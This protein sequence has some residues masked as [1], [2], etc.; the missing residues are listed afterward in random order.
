LAVFAAALALPPALFDFADF[1]GFALLAVLGAAFFAFTALPAFRPFAAA[2]GLRRF[3]GMTAFFARLTT[4]FAVAAADCAAADAADAACCAVSVTTAAALPMVPP[5]ASAVRVSAPCSVLPPAC[6]SDIAA[7]FAPILPHECC[8]A[9]RE[10]VQRLHRTV[11]RPCTSA[12]HAE[13]VSHTNRD[14]TEKRNELA[15]IAGRRKETDRIAR[16]TYHYFDRI[17]AELARHGLVPTPHTA[18]GQLR[19]AVRELYKY[20]IRRLRDEHVAG[21]IPKRDYAGCV[22]QLRERYPLLSV[23]IELWTDAIED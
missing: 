7:P 14:A 3:A 5:T 15:P 19:D 6:S 22:I 9:F 23:P 8:E 12:Q 11:H 10:N 17:L 2:A 16:V 4:R 18:P 13:S 1:A 21:R 20:E